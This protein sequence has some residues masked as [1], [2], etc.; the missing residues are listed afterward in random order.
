MQNF[1]DI[2]EAKEKP[3]FS[4]SSIGGGELISV[5]PRV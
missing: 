3:P 4:Q 5:S 1:V 2:I